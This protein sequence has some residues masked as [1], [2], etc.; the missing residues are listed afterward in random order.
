MNIEL[1]VLCTTLGANITYLNFKRIKDKDS[2]ESGKHQ[3]VTDLKLDYISKGVDDIR[4]DLKA[5]D[6]KIEDINTRLIKVE[7]SSKSAH[8]RIDSLLRE[9]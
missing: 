6:R 8:H 1:G 4:L 3:G 9:D 7:E 2:K 5:A